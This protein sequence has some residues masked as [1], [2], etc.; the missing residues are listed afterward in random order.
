MPPP[1]SSVVAVNLPLKQNATLFLSRY[2][3]FFASDLDFSV[4]FSLE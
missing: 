1:E 2:Y 4:F 3:D